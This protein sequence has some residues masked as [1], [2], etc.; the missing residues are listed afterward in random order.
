MTARIESLRPAFRKIVYAGSSA[1]A[2]Y[3]PGGCACATRELLEAVS[4]VASSAPQRDVRRMQS[5]VCAQTRCVCVM[6][7]PYSAVGSL[8]KG[9]GRSRKVRPGGPGSDDGHQ[10]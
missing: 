4:L 7:R 10:S 2:S 8:L 9:E 3:R 5:S 1:I 6:A